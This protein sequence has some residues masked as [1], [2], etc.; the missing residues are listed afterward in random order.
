MHPDAPYFIILLCLMPDN[1]TCQ[2]ECAAPLNGLTHQTPSAYPL[3]VNL[4]LSGI[5]QSKSFTVCHLISCHSVIFY[6]QNNFI[7][8]ST[9]ATSPIKETQGT[10]QSSVWILFGNC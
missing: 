2:G 8:A 1:F 10:T 5:R 7:L 6:F 4:K 3:T 9:S